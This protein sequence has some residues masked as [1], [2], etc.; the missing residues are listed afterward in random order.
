MPPPLNT[1]A[2]TQPEALQS[3]RE[4]LKKQVMPLKDRSPT[5]PASSGKA[6][7]CS[8]CARECYG[9]IREPSMELLPCITGLLSLVIGFSGE[10]AGGIC[11]QTGSRFQF[12]L[13]NT[14]VQ[15]KG[16]YPVQ[17]QA[18]GRGCEGESSIRIKRNSCGAPSTRGF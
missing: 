5:L 7:R 10:T 6:V 17:E 12:F 9:H 1:E 15:I 11:C 3:G 16:K 2:T 4:R 14:Q 13:R 8:G 18:S